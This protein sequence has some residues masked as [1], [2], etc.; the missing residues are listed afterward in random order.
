MQTAHDIDLLYTD[1]LPST[2]TG[3]LYN[4]F[5]YPTKISPEAIAVFIATHTEPGALVL[6]TFGGS[7]TTGLAAMLC[8]KP[9]EYMRNLVSQIGVTPKWG[10]RRA[11][12][13]EIGV[14][15][16]FVSRTMCSQIDPDAFEKAAKRLIDDAEQASTGLYEAIDS[17]GQLGSIRHTILSDILVCPACDKQASYWEVAVRFKPL[18]LET[19]FRCPHCHHKADLDSVERAVETVLDPLIKKRI[20]RKKRVLARVH[21]ETNGKKWQRE[22]TEDDV[23]RFETIRRRSI[24]KIAPIVPVDWGDLYR[25]GYHKGISHIH[26]FYT[27]RNFLALATLWEKVD[28]APEELRDALRL[29]ILSYNGTHSTLMTRVV[30][31]QGQNDFVLTGAQSG[32]LYISSLPVEKNIFTGIRRKIRTFCEAFALVHGSTSTVDVVNGSSVNINLPDRSVDYVFT[33]PPFGDFIPYAEVNE[34][35]EVWLGPITQRRS[36]IVISQAQGKTVEAYGRLMGDVFSEIARTLKDDG[37]ATV[38]FH[39]AKAEVWQSLC[40]AYLDAG[41]AVKATSVLD[42]LQA[43]FKQVVSTVTVKGD[44]LLLLQKAPVAK[45]N[46]DNAA[47]R[48]RILAELLKE[49]S[50]HAEGSKERT[51]ERLYSRFVARC[52]EAGIPVGIDAAEFYE[53]VRDSLKAMTSGPSSNGNAKDFCDSLDPVRKKRLGQYFTEPKLSRFLANVAGAAKAHTVIDPFAGL[54]DM[55]IA[56]NGANPS[57]QLSAIEIDQA[58]CDFGQKR[59]STECKGDVAFILG[60]AFDWSV[61]A[62]LPTKSFDLVITNPPYV[63]YQSFAKKGVDECSTPDAAGVRNALRTLIDKSSTLDAADRNLLTTLVQGYSG[64]ADLAVPAWLL[65]AM[66]TRIG[67]TLAMVVPE[68]WLTR[69]YAQAIQY[70]LLRWFRIRHVIEDANAAWFPEAQVKTTL[71][72]AERIQRRGSIFDWK[73]EGYLRTQISGSASDDRSIVGNIEKGAPN[74]DGQFAHHLEALLRL[75]RGEERPLWSTRWVSMLEKAEN[76][77]SAAAGETWFRALEGASD[78]TDR[79]NHNSNGSAVIPTELRSWLGTTSKATFTSLEHI[80]VQ[81]GQGLR[82]G[83]NTF[84]YVDVESVSDHDLLIRAHRSLKVEKVRVPSECVETVLRK[85]AE[86]GPGYR[87]DAT[88]LTGRVLV[89]Q[90]FALSEDMKAVAKV[91]RVVANAIRAAYIPMPADLVKLV[92]AAAIRAEHNGSEE[93]YIPEFSAVRTNVR[94]VDPARPDVLPRWWYMLPPFAPRHRPELVIG[95]VNGAPPRAVLNDEPKVVVD[96]NFSTMWLRPDASVDVYA[97]LAVLN[98][99]WAVTAME[100]MGSVMGGGALKLEA[101]HLRKLPIPVFE[102]SERRRLSSL[103]KALVR[104]S[105]P[106]ATLSVIDEVIMKALFGEVAVT[107]QLATLTRIR[108][109]HINARARTT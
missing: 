17:H 104:A 93:R 84:F 101:T 36:E 53:R 77:R 44:P 35:N 79:T 43:T 20:T 12:V 105:D 87:L 26:H 70:L 14:L 33:D 31:K 82:T 94:K 37:R 49:T 62:G 2:R 11:A 68:A 46:G 48:E 39:S 85:Q 22:A 106:A 45:P 90:N 21:G 86:I 63:R 57:Q 81:V 40:K 73:D 6:D 8:D 32:V 3:A 38:V 103:G 13:Y 9:T 107:G 52:L 97:L 92:N 76:L 100:C 60:S 83:A 108:D 74:P 78:A 72:I 75:R 24:P 54:G 109:N 51:P 5:S 47:A 96:A 27:H 71:I 98:S 4:A 30:V 69:D 91:S 10:P 55:I 19:K 59:C 23:R 29:L 95:R 99:T 61:L 66:L 65:C 58:V 56:S 16:S 102:K 18:Q 28:G 42:K 80:G 1:P 88:A 50:T 64:L 7:G 15:G 67:G 34:I 41:L 89:F 25:S